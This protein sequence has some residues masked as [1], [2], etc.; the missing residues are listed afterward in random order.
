MGSAA[1]TSCARRTIRVS[2][3][4]L[5]GLFALGESRFHAVEAGPIGALLEDVGAA[6]QTPG[7][8]CLGGTSSRLQRDRRTKQHS[9]ENSKPRT[10]T[11]EIGS[12]QLGDPASTRGLRGMPEGNG[13]APVV[14]AAGHRVAM[15]S[16]PA[17]R[18]PENMVQVILH[19][20]LQHRARPKGYMPAFRTV[21]RRQVADMAVRIAAANLPRTSP[22]GTRICNEPWL[23]DQEIAR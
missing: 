16:K 9:R 10:G 15:N 12:G 3:D 13:G 19:G 17:Q 4:E 1:A 7:N 20:T 21:F 11:R 23:S 5:F 18:H 2:E 8:L 6:A 22:H 14:R